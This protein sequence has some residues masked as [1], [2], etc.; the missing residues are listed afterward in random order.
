MSKN[1]APGTAKK[2][3]FRIVFSGTA[4]DAAEHEQTTYK[5]Q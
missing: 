5:Q 4:G 1:E 2:G 3:L